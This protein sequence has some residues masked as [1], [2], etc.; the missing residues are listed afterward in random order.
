MITCVLRQMFV[1]KCVSSLELC[2]DEVTQTKFI[3]PI[4]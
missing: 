4:N 1:K 2:G 3:G